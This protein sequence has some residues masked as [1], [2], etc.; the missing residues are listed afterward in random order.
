MSHDLH[1]WAPDATFEQTIQTISCIVLFTDSVRN[2]DGDS[3]EVEGNSVMTS[4]T[5]RGDSLEVQGSNDQ[6]WKIFSEL[7]KDSPNILP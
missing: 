1:L 6:M 4:S 5:C 3:A 2:C 7:N